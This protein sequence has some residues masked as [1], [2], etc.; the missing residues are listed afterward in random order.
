MESETA[1]T[2]Y[3]ACFKNSKHM[4]ID[5]EYQKSFWSN[6]NPI[7]NCEYGQQSC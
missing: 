7:I 1:V 4:K 2:I 3:D 6:A 5:L